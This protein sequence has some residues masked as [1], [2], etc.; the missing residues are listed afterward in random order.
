M[1]ALHHALRRF[2]TRPTFTL[3]AVA[4]LALAI[5]ANAAI[6][7]LVQAVLLRPLAFADPGALVQ[8][9][10]FDGDDQQVGN[11]SPADFFDFARES[12]VFASMGG[13]GS[14]TRSR[15]PARPATPNALGSERHRRVLSDARRSSGLGT[16]VHAF[17]RPARCRV[18]GGAR[19]RLLAAPLRG[20]PLSDRADHPN[21]RSSGDHH[22]RAACL[23]SPPGRGPRSRS[24]RV[25]SLRFQSSQRE[26]WRSFHPRGRAARAG[27]V[28]GAGTSRARHDCCAPRTRISN[29][30]P[31]GRCSVDTASRVG[32]RRS[33]A[34]PRAG[35][36]GR[37]PRAA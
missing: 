27:R 29:Q 37:R 31:R 35:L 28:A 3:V 22:R 36:G 6:F 10:G 8:V 18:D 33:T 7:S 19:R 1:G 23:V 14:S 34:Q 11:L 26:S 13:T 32:R 12:R 25:H 2:S 9:R 17:R 24:G 21:Q 5:G 16:A 30:Q 4:T 15:L 20:R